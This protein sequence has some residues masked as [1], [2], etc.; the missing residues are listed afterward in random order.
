MLRPVADPRPSARYLIRERATIRETLEH[1]RGG[2][3]ML[4]HVEPLGVDDPLKRAPV[5]ETHRDGGDAIHG[6]G[7]IGLMAAIRRLREL[8]VHDL[9]RDILERGAIRF[10]RGANSLT[11]AGVPNADGPVLEKEPEVAGIGG[12]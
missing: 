2:V 7:I 11:N 9:G 12:E 8:R 5:H 10:E 4:M 6:D 1:L 3:E